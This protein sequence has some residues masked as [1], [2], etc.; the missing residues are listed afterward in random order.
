MRGAIKH[1]ALVEVEYFIIIF[2]ICL[3]SKNWQVIAKK[4]KVY[5]TWSECNRTY[6]QA[7]KKKKCFIH[8]ATALSL[9][10]FKAVWLDWRGRGEET[11]VPCWSRLIAMPTA[12]VW[13]GTRGL[14]ARRGALNYRPCG[15]DYIH[16]HRNSL[17]H[18]LYRREQHSLPSSHVI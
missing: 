4:K 3:N 17:I 15:S 1:L 13:G 11:G 18:K 10:V 9:L 7:K 5:T 14:C 8:T 12:A 6:L 2:F 16:C